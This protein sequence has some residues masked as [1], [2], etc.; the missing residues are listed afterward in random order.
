[1]NL[2]CLRLWINLEVVETGFNSSA[3]QG[4][5]F[6]VC[7]RESSPTGLLVCAAVVLVAR[8]DDI[9][10]GL[11]GRAE[12]PSVHGFE[13]AIW[14]VHKCETLGRPLLERSP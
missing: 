5:T 9:G 10:G 4:R 1:M 11:Y 8:E 14:V 13:P 12:R 3:L 2:I 7:G 6:H